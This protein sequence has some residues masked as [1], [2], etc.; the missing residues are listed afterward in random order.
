[1]ADV[2]RHLQVDA[3][4]A[5]A[6]SDAKNQVAAES[7]GLSQA[8]SDDQDQLHHQRDLAESAVSIVSPVQY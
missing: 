6:E 7:D 5:V 2:L 8:K 1:M 4:L 3:Q